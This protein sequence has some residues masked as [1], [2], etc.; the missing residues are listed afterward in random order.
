M[1]RSIGEGRL[2]VKYS[3]GKTRLG[4]LYQK[5]NAKIRIPKS[6]SGSLDAVLINTSGG[7]TGG[8][9]LNWDIEAQAGSH[10][11]VTTQACEK[12]YRSS[13]GEARLSTNITAG[14]NACVE[15]LPQESILFDESRLR[16]KIDVTLAPT[17]DFIGLEAVV[18]GRVAM[19]E[20][21]GRISINDQWRI[22]RGG[23]LIHADNTQFDGDITQHIKTPAILNAKTGSAAY[24][25][26]VYCPADMQ[27]AVSAEEIRFA[28]PNSSNWGVSAMPQKIIARFVADD[29]Y[30]LRQVLMP[31]LRTFRRGRALPDTW[32]I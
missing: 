11:V 12:I 8:D 19:N 27:T 16:R 22:R 30:S 7:M 9:I 18:L 4:D 24:A 10:A 6:Y 14:Q 29:M 23:M 5:A 2:T 32:R 25:T 20:F 1:Q 17:A 13:G 28:A 31:V 26:L 15:W 3:G 21:P